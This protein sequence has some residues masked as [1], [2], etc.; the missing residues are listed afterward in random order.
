MPFV[1]VITTAVVD[2][3][4][5]DTLQKEIGRIIAIIPGKTIDNCMTKIEGSASVFMSGTRANAVFCE[6]RLFGIAPTEAKAKV[7]AELHALF[8]RELSAQKVYMNYL[9]SEEWGSKYMK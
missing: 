5:M 6:V 1:S 2:E 7:T 9:E 8:T 4:T 3:K